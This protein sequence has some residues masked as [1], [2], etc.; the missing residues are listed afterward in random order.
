MAETRA[1]HIRPA[2]GLLLTA[3]ALYSASALAVPYAITDLGT[4]GGTLSRAFGINNSGQVV[5]AA[6]LD[7]G[8]SHPFLYSNGTMS[9]L[10][11]L[12]GGT[13]G[14][15]FS[16]NNSGQIAGSA[17]TA[18][19]DIRAFLYSDGSM[20]NL[21]TL[22]GN[23]S[24]ASGINDSGQV[25]GWADSTSAVR[26]F[27][28]SNGSMINLGSLSDRASQASA[29]NDNGEIAGWYID[30]TGASVHAFVYSNGSM[31]DIGTLGS[32]PSSAAF[33]INNSGQVVGR[34]HNTTNID[35]DG[36]AFLYSN[37]LMIDLGTLGGTSSWAYGINDSGQVVGWADTAD[38][39]PH[40]FL[41]SGDSMTDLS[42]LPEVLAAGWTS[43][44]EA[45][46]INDKGQI[47][48]YGFIGGNYRAF[49]L[50]PIPEPATLS[51]MGLGLLG[52]AARRR[53]RVAGEKVT[54]KSGVS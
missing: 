42:Q 53:S 36:R 19:G 54:L 46:G 49:L 26:A 8:Y 38:G 13:N 18:G 29:I 12:D 50:S 47:V 33:D 24:Q 17:Y 6:S 7:S 39:D 28:Y 20:N 52:M 32:S 2:S 16:I 51:L 5:G 48:G 15:A 22:G 40:A 35:P 11:T 37:G 44:D 25:V 34:V 9:D 14:V 27:L 3:F 31:I 1:K 41:Y 4:L 30:N 43:L 23:R 21:G 10:G 45:R